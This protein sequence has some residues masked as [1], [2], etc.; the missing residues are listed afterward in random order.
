MMHG[1]LKS[2][3]VLLSKEGVA[4][5]ADVGMSRVHQD[6]VTVQ[7]VMT[8]LWA[9]PDVSIQHASIHLPSTILVL[10]DASLSNSSSSSSSNAGRCSQS[11][12]RASML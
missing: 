12:P 1:D 5:L 7:A 4:K 9:S 11:L 6:L 3:N 10:K 8:P 2:P